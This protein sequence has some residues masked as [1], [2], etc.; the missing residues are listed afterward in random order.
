[1][2][3][4]DFIFLTNIPAFYK[5]SLYNKIAEKYRILVIFMYESGSKRNSDFYNQPMRFEH[6]FT[7]KWH[8]LKLL[9]ILLSVRYK[10][11]VI[12]GY[13]ELF[14]WG[15]AF[16]S[17][18]KKN[19]L[20]LESSYH[21]SVIHGWKSW[22]KKI[23]FTRVFKIY[24]SGAANVK[25]VELLGYS[26]KKVTTYGV[27]LYRRTTPPAFVPR[28]SIKNFIYVG[29]LSPE[30][31]LPYLLEIFKEIPQFSLTVVGFGPQEQELKNMAPANVTFTGA[32]DNA[33]LPEYYRNADVFILFSKSE[34]WGLVVEEAM[35]NG[36]P[37]ILSDRIGCAEEIV[38]DGKNGFIVP[39]NDK[40][41]LL[42]TIKK[43]A[44]PEIYNKL[45]QYVCNTDYESV[46]KKQI[47]AYEPGI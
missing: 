12:G 15:A 11:L 42:N 29:R 33:R 26:G 3:N 25:L 10:E 20:V 21:E 41:A 28:T 35:N 46:E 45:R 34:P 17:S 5:I 31:N 30:K 44:E 9:K 19:S 18:P 40:D 39:L 4:Y 37:V 1:M 24:C 2:K 8:T 6:I 43:I 14:Y 47:S 36:L 22:L 32:V 23:F 13:Q 38:R 7:C 27:G 16:L